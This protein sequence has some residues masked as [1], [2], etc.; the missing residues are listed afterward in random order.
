MKY[1]SAYF[2]EKL[3]KNS[4][5]CHLLNLPIEWYTKYKHTKYNS[6]EKAKYIHELQTEN[7]YHAM[8]K[9]SR[10]QLILFF[11]LEDRILHFMQIVSYIPSGISCK[12]SPKDTICMKYQILLEDRILH[13]MQIVLHEISDPY[14]LLHAICLLR[15]QF[16]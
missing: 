15:R 10:C 1:Q 12:L 3:R 8:G 5:I 9:F 2:L 16:A 13:F 11:F 6:R 4:S 7:T 14:F